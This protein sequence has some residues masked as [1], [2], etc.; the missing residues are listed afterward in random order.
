[1][2]H[3]FPLL[4]VFFF[5]NLSAQAGGPN[6]P[7]RSQLNPELYPFYHG[8]ASG[9]P[10]ADRVI[11]WTRITLDPTVDPVN[12]NWQIALDT[13]F[14][15]V[16]N[17]GV[18]ATDSTV[19]YTIKVDATGLQPNTWYYYRFTY[20]TLKSIIGR[21]K[22]LPVGMVNNL[23]FA[24]AS[25][26]DY[27]D[28]FYNA[29]RHLSQRN[30]VDAVLFLGDYTYEGGP[31]QVALADRI[32]EPAK[33]TIELV[34]YRIRQSQYHLDP[35]L[36]AA[37]QQYPW[38]CIW[39][40]HETTNNSYT[41]GAKNHGVNDGD[42]YT[43]KTNAVKAYHEWLPVRFPDEADTFRIFRQF[44]FG[45][46]ISLNMIDTRLYDRSKQATGG[47]FIPV[48]DSVVTDS[49]RTMVGPV[50]FDWLNNN[51]DTSNAR[52]QIIGQQ[53]I[54]TPLIIPPG[55]AG[56]TPVMINSDQ[57]DG[58]PYEREKL[59]KHILDNNIDNI[60]VLTGDIH[61]AWAN[62]LPLQGYSDTTRQNSI[63]V[64]FVTPSISSGNELPQLV[65]P[66]TIYGLAPH[67]RFVDL[68]EHG[69]YILDVNAS[70]VQSDFVFFTDVKTQVYS[71]VPGPSWYVNDGEKFL[72]TAATA[73][74]PA[75]TYPPLAPN[76]S[77]ST[78][79]N[80]LTGSITT[81]M[82]HPNPFYDQVIVQFNAAKAEDITL[83]V[84][85]A[86]GQVVLKSNLGKADVGLNHAT[87]NGSNFASGFYTIRLSGKK[88]TKSERV[89]KIN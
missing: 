8:V 60:V 20:D 36:Q 6:D 40:D 50:Q 22:T 7:S 35:D 14:N 57:W 49:T 17:S 24:V 30:D 4:L 62:D 12:V 61:T 78:S 56:P 75:N 43:R 83:E 66:I 44:N 63:G 46:L 41:D 72:R 47:Q 1:M 19:D 81:I 13:N 86:N 84:L 42:W 11:L 59:Y 64:E 25:C 2:K 33:K 54:M 15:S 39:D 23:R 80:N 65:T 28:G 9:D 53:V 21:T 10:L 16:V 37:H 45:N 29:H 38:I 51:L 48:T 74:A 58:Y 68:T 70:R 34:D 88:N 55:F 71:T 87:F 69:Y 52:W 85:N 3:L 31:L 32:H 79:I 18:A 5:A 76:N 26:Q 67:V 77:F 27:Q 89:I 82:I 73:S